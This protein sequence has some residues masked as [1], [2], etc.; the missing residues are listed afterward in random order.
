[1]RYILTFL[2]ILGFATIKH[3]DFRY[4]IVAFLGSI[5]VGAII[6]ICFWKEGKWENRRRPM[7]TAAKTVTAYLGKA[8]LCWSKNRKRPTTNRVVVKEAKWAEV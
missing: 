1:M 8:H 3:I 4:V 2:A 5:V 6:T 7:K